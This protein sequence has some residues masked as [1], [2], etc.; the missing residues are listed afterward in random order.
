M[1]KRFP[2]F[3]HETATGFDKIFVSVWKVGFHIEL[4]PEDLISVA[5]C[6][7]ADIV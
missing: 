1:K 6:K 4:S 3:I 7:V 5:G 2:A